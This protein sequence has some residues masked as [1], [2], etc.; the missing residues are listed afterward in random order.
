MHGLPMIETERALIFPK[1][2][3]PQSPEFSVETTVCQFQSS[4]K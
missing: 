3:I 4:L 1:R 2:R